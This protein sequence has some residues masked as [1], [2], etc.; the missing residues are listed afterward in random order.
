ML[1]RAPDAIVQPDTQHQPAP[2]RSAQAPIPDDRES[3]A[4]PALVL[5]EVGKRFGDG[6]WLF[7]QLNIVIPA[8]QTV[9][10]QGESGSGKSTLLNLIAGIEPA[11][12]GLINV[13]GEDVARLDDRGAA[14]LRASKLGFVFQAFH[15][16][17][18]LQVWRN[19][20]LPLLLNDVP[21][22]EARARAQLALNRLGLLARAHALPG[23][24]SGG[25]Q[26]RVA[27]LRAL[28]H[29]PKLV[30]ADEPTGNL[31]PDSARL[32]LDL[33]ADEVRTSGAALLLVTHSAAA[34]RICERH[35]RLQNTQLVE[36]EPPFLTPTGS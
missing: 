16:L 14:R 26:Q 18:N 35:L 32:A 36:S 29:Q 1:P 17:P 12:E 27:L 2:P 8:G 23:E 33:L 21:L 7:R 5:R 15:L 6:R 25:E 24:L 4:K 3:A 22:H 11:G 31:D 30:L 20:A 13:D 28:I 9:S 19:L 10:L 34:A